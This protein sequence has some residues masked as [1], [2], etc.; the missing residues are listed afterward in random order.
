MSLNTS[1]CHTVALWE[2]LQ[3]GF[4]VQSQSLWLQWCWSV[5]PYLD[6]LESILQILV[7][8]VQC[9]IVCADHSTTAWYQFCFV[10]TFAPT[11]SHCISHNRGKVQLVWLMNTLPLVHLHSFFCCVYIGSFWGVVR[12]TMCRR[13]VEKLVLLVICNWKG[14]II[15]RLFLFRWTVFTGMRTVQKAESNNDLSQLHFCT[16]SQRDV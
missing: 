3:F 11:H 14:K 10:I 15:N 9:Q 4:H 12:V 5:D 2:H 16:C 13:S 6:N 1:T 8:K 7:L